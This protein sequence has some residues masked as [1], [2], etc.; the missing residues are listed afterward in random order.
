[1]LPDLVLA[2]PAS[3][4]IIGYVGMC[5]PSWN[6]LVLSPELSHFSAFPFEL[7]TFPCQQFPSRTLQSLSQQLHSAFAFPISHALS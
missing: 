7:Y 2:H 5:W 6:W 1:M 3:Q 4:A